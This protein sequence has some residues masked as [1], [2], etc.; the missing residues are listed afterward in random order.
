MKKIN[1]NIVLGLVTFLV[2]FS[3]YLV[4]TLS[5]GR[6][7]LVIDQVL[8]RPTEIIAPNAASEKQIGKIGDV[9]IGDIV[10]PLYRHL[11]AND[12]VDREFTFTRILQAEGDRW[13]VEKPQLSFFRPD[14]SVIISSDTADV[15]TETVLKEPRPKDASLLGN[16]IVHI[17]PKEAGNMK[18]SFAYFDSLSFESDSSRAFT[19]GPLRLV[20][21][22]FQLEGRK[23]EFVY[24]G[25]LRRLEFLR[26]NELKSLSVKVPAKSLSLTPDA[27]VGGKNVS[28]QKKLHAVEINTQPQKKDTVLSNA[29]QTLYRCFFN[30]NVKVDS[31]NQLIITDQFIINNILINQ[32]SSAKSKDADAAFVAKQPTASSEPAAKEQSSELMPVS[33]T[34]QDGI[35]VT[36]MDSQRMPPPLNA[37]ETIVDKRLIDQYPGIKNKA[38]IIGRQLTFDA[39]SIRLP[40]QKTAPPNY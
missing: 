7:S 12:M 6:K 30:K 2:I 17:V 5:G 37:A 26:I 39:I 18:E 21:E 3:V 29:A 8:P 16:V 14:L 35:L 4:I 10:N 32:T 15:Q 34:C 11:D 38:F 22:D 24:N 31:N 13:Q 27:N 19:D 1:R 9:N 33:I 20:S 25:Q 28:A 36:P 23:M 40:F